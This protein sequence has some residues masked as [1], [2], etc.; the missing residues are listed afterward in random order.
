MAFNNFETR[1]I[2][3]PS[4]PG[5]EEYDVVK[6]DTSSPFSVPK[7]GSYHLYFNGR[8]IYLYSYC[9]A[10][11]KLI[12]PGEKAHTKNG[13]KQYLLGN[14]GDGDDHS[15]LLNDNHPNKKAMELYN[16]NKELVLYLQYKKKD[17]PWETYVTE[18]KAK[19]EETLLMGKEAWREGSVLFKKM[20]AGLQKMDENVQK[21]VEALQKRE[22]LLQKRMEDVR[23]RE[24]ALQKREE[25]FQ[26]KMKDFQTKEA[27]FHTKVAESGHEEG[28]DGLQSELSKV[29]IQKRDF[30]SAFC[31]N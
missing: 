13:H 3:L 17:M 9:Q 25:L 30:D 31:Q 20:Q 21:R 22:E 26:E 10:C 16:K 19:E 18:M 14:Y 1:I 28:V 5:D 24:E 11:Q 2:F 7:N 12:P 8:Q 4:C 27:A 6:N 29:S 15:S 23:T